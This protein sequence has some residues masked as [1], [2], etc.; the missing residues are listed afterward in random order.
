M[1][2]RT[3]TERLRE[4]LDER[5]MRWR[6]GELIH[7]S[8]D[9]ITLWSVDGHAVRA[10]EYKDGRLLIETSLTPEQAIAM[11]DSN[12]DTTRDMEAER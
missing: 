9:D 4:M 1:T 12:D 10:D 6:T 2:H 3:A 5:G 11:F 7:R 8:T